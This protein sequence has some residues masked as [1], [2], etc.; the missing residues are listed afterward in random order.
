M[1]SSIIIFIL[2]FAILGLLLGFASIFNSNEGRQ[3][4]N[5]A[6]QENLSITNMTRSVQANNNSSNSMQ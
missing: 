1:W 5:S 4:T 2:T 6:L 3:S